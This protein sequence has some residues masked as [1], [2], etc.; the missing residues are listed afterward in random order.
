MAGDRQTGGRTRQ[1][2][3][4][5]R[6]DKIGTDCRWNGFGIELWGAIILLDLFALRLD[7]HLM[8]E[9]YAICLQVGSASGAEIQFGIEAAHAYG[10]MAFG[11]EM[12]LVLNLGPGFLERIGLLLVPF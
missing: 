7:V 6:F 3:T 12:K 2:T 8:L 9:L 5:S 4:P 10:A 1:A 11:A